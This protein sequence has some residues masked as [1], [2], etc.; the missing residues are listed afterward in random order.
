MNTPQSASLGCEVSSS[1]DAHDQ[2]RK[3]IESAAH[4]LPSQGPITTFIHHNTLHAFEDLPFDDAVKKGTRVFGCQPYLPEQEYRRLLNSDR[5]RSSDL[6]TVLLEVLG[7]GVDGLIGRLGTRF[8]LRLAMLQ[9]PLQMGPSAEL[10]WL[11]AETEALRKFRPEVSASLRN[12]MINQTRHWVMRDLL[13]GQHDPA[14]SEQPI[15]EKISELLDRFGRSSIESWSDAT[16]EAFC[17]QLLWRV[18]HQGMHAPASFALPRVA[19]VR[20]RDLLLKSTGEDSDRL[21]HDLLIRLCA[22]FVDQGFANWK[23]AQRDQGFYR[24]FISLY[25]MGGGPPDRW[26]RGLTP[27]LQRLSESCI[28][29]CDSIEE[30]LQILGVTAADRERFV[31]ETLLALRG[32]AG[33]IWQMETSNENDRVVHP[34]PAGSL[35]EFL[36]VRLILE[37]LALTHI[38]KESLGFSGDLRNLPTKARGR[39]PKPEAGNVDQRTFLVF[40]LSQVLGWTPQELHHL[41]HQ[42]WSKLAQ[43]IESF[44]SL[45]RRRIF[46]EAYERRYYTQALDAVAVH[47]DRV[48]PPRKTASFQVICCIDEREE[49]FRR[50]LEEVAPECETLGVAGFFAVAMY[51]R[52]AVDAH[53][54]PLCPAI[55]VPRHYVCE[56]VVHTYEES[57]RRRAKTRRVI[58]TASHQMH[59]RSRT[60]ASGALLTGLLGP[61]ASIPLVARILFPR[62]TAQIRRLFGGFIQP[63]RLTELQLERTEPDPSPEK[64][65]LGFSLPEMAGIVER[66]LRDIGLTSRFAPLI[67]ITG[68]GSSSLNN[69]HEAAHDCGA[70]GGAR[71]GPNARAFAR[72]AN[73]SRVRDLVAQNGLEIPS[74]S[75]FVGAYHN[76]CDDS[77]TYFDLDPLPITHQDIFKTASKAID[78][79]RERNAHER[80]RRFESAPLNPS[81]EAAL[82]HV[83]GRA[84][85]LAQVRPEYGHATNA[86]CF[87]GRR[88]RNRGLF[89]DRRAFLSSYDP[90]QDNEVS[91]VLTRILQAVIPVCSG[92]SLEYYFSFVDPT[93][94]GCGTKL[95]HNVTSLLGVMDGAASDL[96]PGLPWQM[97]E[98]HEP[99]RLLFI[100]ETTPQAMLQIMDRNEAIG[101]LCRNNWVQIATQDPDSS[102]LHVFRQGKFEVYVPESNELL[103]VNSS[104]DWYRG[105]RDHLG[106]ASIEVPETDDRGRVVQERRA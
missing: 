83:E 85:D 37:R 90:T 63:P 80:C 41:S 11:V 67:V 43:E 82:R 59:L 4:L 91:T 44:S 46:H 19:P 18:C 48:A 86:L 16:W 42:E 40:Q 61:L 100:I 72:M 71:G 35:L 33:M 103:W 7:D 81:T 96:R 84:E 28:G 3:L 39:I 36:A 75:Y 60:F 55:M 98:I 102:E 15:R 50:H 57:H 62:L 97:V 30:S 66:L 20:H 25:G 94:W 77:V 10:R 5:I 51:Y 38:A 54:T 74:S 92:I 14:P 104:L 58:G 23:L 64:G 56:D 24:A 76:T 29:P 105:W 13:S 2:L 9:Y 53:F 21:V 6:R 106:F 95:P 79:A 52:G 26:L 78:S 70:C 34:A 32:W 12:R 27:E 87:V 73:D 1:T 8:H 22:A 69:P 89:L 45:E 101:K 49:S 99:M 17:M 88:W 47:A 93:G 68:H 31:T 65:H